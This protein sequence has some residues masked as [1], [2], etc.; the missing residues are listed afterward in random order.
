MKYNY[1][2][3]Y[4]A[5]ECSTSVIYICGIQISGLTVHVRF[6]T[7]LLLHEIVS[8]YSQQLHLQH[9]CHVSRVK[10]QLPIYFLDTSYRNALLA[11]IQLNDDG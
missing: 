3:V 5:L 6:Y 10:F 9:G 4:T 7:S 1:I 2:L 8:L 11:S